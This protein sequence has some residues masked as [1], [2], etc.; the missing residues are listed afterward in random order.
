M[1]ATFVQQ[2]QTNIRAVQENIVAACDVAGRSPDEVTLIAV[3]K[4]RSVAEIEAAAEAGI[5]DFGENRVEEGNTKIETLANSTKTLRWHMIGHVQSR[6]A[7]DVVQYF[8]VVHSVDSEKLLG[9]LD[10]FAEDVD[11]TIDVLLQVNVS[12]EDTKSGLF[13]DNWQN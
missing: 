5:V 7:R 4:Q 9:R 6:K 8:D 12:G 3:S 10:R 1:N 2:I 13:V 11:R